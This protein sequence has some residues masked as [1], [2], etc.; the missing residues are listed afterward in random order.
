MIEILKNKNATTKFQILVEIANS[1]PKV[2]Q[3][4]IAQRLDITPQAISDYVTQLI[5]EKM[6]TSNERSKYHI[7]NEGV[8]WIIKMLKELNIY[9]NYVQEAIKNIS[10]CAA[11]AEIDLEKNRKV[12]LRMKNGMLFATG[13]SSSQATGT[14]VSSAGAGEDIGITNIEGIVPM[15]VGKVTILIIPAIQN[16]GSSKVNYNKLKKYLKNSLFVVSIGLESSVVLQKAGN[17]YYRYGAADAAIEAAK[18]G[19]SPLVLCVENET[20][21]LIVLL[22]KEKISYETIGVAKS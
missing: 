13:N 12:G 15:Q 14:T 20:A 22:E 17:S 19:L 18:S 16:G 6:L 9:I 10:I 7:T 11:I 5:D 2:Q 1:G 3:R 4:D 21:E 8:N